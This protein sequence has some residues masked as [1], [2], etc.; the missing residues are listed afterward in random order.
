MYPNRDK[1]KTYLKS[2][3]RIL[4]SSTNIQPI[5]KS[6]CPDAASSSLFPTFTNLRGWTM[7]H[8]LCFRSQRWLHQVR[9]KKKGIPNERRIHRDQRYIYLYIKHLPQ[10]IE[11]YSGFRA[12]DR[13]MVEHHVGCVL[14]IGYYDIEYW[15][16]SPKRNCKVGYKRVIK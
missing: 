13:L 4:Q 10:I 14:K 12:L 16:L 9:W 3:P 1:H 5:R 7:R 15:C 6:L 2:P 8:F 11:R